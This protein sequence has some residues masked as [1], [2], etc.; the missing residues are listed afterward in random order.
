MKNGEGLEMVE[1]PV[2]GSWAARF[3]PFWDAVMWLQNDFADDNSED[4]VIY[5][6]VAEILLTK[7]KEVDHWLRGKQ[8]EIS[9]TAISGF[10]SSL[11]IAPQQEEFLKHFFPQLVGKNLPKLTDILQ[12]LVKA[13]G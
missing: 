3:E 2:A 12:D 5:R 10:P 7:S 11:V 6:T 13:L 8:A 1:P 4:G 9:R